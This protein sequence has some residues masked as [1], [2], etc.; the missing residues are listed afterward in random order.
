LVWDYSDVRFEGKIPLD[1]RTIILH[2]L[3]KIVE[4]RFSIDSQFDFR[5]KDEYEKTTDYANK[6]QEALNEFNKSP[7]ITHPDTYRFDL[8]KKYFTPVVDSPEISDASY[9]ADS[10]TLTFY[11]KSLCTRQFF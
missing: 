9:N 8:L 5:N 4:D 6:R 3:N 1:E 2:A 11:I 10:E 7:P